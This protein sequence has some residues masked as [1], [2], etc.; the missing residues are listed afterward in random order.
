MQE[1]MYLS[2]C[3]EY[4]FWYDLGSCSKIGTIQGSRPRTLKYS[5]KEKYYVSFKEKLVSVENRNL[6]ATKVRMALTVVALPIL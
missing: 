3:G 6:W 5:A 1:N 4:C 2:H